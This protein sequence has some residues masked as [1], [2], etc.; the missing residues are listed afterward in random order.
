MLV[1]VACDASRNPLLIAVVH[2][3]SSNGDDVGLVVSFGEVA[4]FVVTGG[5]SCSASADNAGRKKAE[6]VASKKVLPM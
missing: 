5:P 6:A 1:E 4:L 3:C 2:R